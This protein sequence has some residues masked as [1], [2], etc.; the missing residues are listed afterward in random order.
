MVYSFF[1]TLIGF[2]LIP[3]SAALIFISVEDNA[4]K[5]FVCQ[6]QKSV[7]RFAIVLIINSLFF[8]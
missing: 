6:A 7:A 2:A 8:G 3:Q 5:W 1:L 4:F